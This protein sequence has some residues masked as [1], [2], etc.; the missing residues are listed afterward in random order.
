MFVNTIS[1]LRK[2]GA[3]T[4]VTGSLV[5]ASVSTPAPAAAAGAFTV[6][7]SPAGN[8]GA[9]ATLS[10]TILPSNQYLL[11]LTSTGTGTCTLTGPIV[12]IADFDVRGFGNPVTAT[13]SG[14]CTLYNAVVTYTVTWTGVT[15]SSGQFPVVCTWV[16]GMRRCSVSS[17]SVPSPI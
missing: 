6:T 1:R 8:G 17:F 3:I 10:D 15:G 11:T 7:L 4:A 16:L 14:A 12:Q 5:A 13:V 9:T 2:A